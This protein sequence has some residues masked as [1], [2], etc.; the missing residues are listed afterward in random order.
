MFAVAAHSHFS[1]SPSAKGCF[2]MPSFNDE[3]VPHEAAHGAASLQLIDGRGAFDEAGLESFLRTIRLSECGV[4][5][6]V[7]AI[8]G[9]QS[10]GMILLHI[11]VVFVSLL[12]SSVACGLSEISIRAI[13]A[14]LFAIS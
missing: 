6:A 4:S 1:R 7:V 9:P 5:Y 10:S 2:K 8:M 11:S 3:R 12:C 13:L 14:R